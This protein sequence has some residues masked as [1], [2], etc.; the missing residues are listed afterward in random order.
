MYNLSNQQGY[1]YSIENYTQF[2]VITYKEK[3]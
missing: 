3:E 1:L 2:F